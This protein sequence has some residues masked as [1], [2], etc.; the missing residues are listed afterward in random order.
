VSEH[1][2]NEA[3]GKVFAMNPENL[4]SIIRAHMVEEKN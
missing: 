3:G 2:A 1:K 4:C